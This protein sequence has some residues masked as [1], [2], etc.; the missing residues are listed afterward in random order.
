[1]SY[2]KICTDPLQTMIWGGIKFVKVSTCVDIL[3]WLK[4]MST[5]GFSYPMWCSLWEFQK[6]SCAHFINCFKQ[7]AYN[8]IEKPNYTISHVRRHKNGMEKGLG[9]SYV[10]EICCRTSLL[11]KLFSMTKCL[12]TKTNKRKSVSPHGIEGRKHLPNLPNLPNYVHKHCWGA[13]TTRKHFSKNSCCTC[14]NW[15]IS[16]WLH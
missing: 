10:V 8:A 5:K 3:A 12:D 16:P 13:I 2:Y 14:M 15:L 4:S 9:S 6:L 11:N 1:M 7:C